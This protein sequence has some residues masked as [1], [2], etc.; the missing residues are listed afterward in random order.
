MLRRTLKAAWWGATLQL[1]DRLRARR[2]ALLPAK[3]AIPEPMDPSPAPV[4]ADELPPPTPDQ[5]EILIPVAA[6]PIVSVIIPTYG[7]VD[8]TLRCLVS[9]AEHPPRTPIEVIVMEDA[10]G[11]PNVVRLNAVSGILLIRN[12]WNMGF[13]DTCNAGA[14]AAAGRYLLFLNND[15]ELR[16]GAIDALVDLLEARPDAGMAGSKLIFPD[17]RL[18]EAGGIVWNDASGSNHGR[19]DD[20]AKPEVLLCPR[21]GLLFRC[22]HTCS[23]ISVR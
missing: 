7:H 17:G 4:L 13:L 8:F 3:S 23:A 16:P 19:D 5:P 22:L 1:K 15:T 21:S 9:I 20:P 18:Q 10:S 2:E 12:A 6:D 11:D 14:K